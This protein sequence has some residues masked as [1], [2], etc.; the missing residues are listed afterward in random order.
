M[1]AASSKRCDRRRSSHP[2]DPS[3][4]FPRKDV[5]AHLRA[6][7][8]ICTD[9]AQKRSRSLFVGGKAEITATVNNVLDSDPPVI[10]GQGGYR[11]TYPSTYEITR[12]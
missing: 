2:A 9:P 12:A 4:G 11:N 7:E 5:R 3:Q 8:P 6:T 10:V 1:K